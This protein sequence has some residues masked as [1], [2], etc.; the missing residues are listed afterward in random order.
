MSTYIFSR[1]RSMSARK[2]ERDLYIQYKQYEHDSYVMIY[3]DVKFNDK[4]K[5]KR[6]GLKWNLKQKT[7]QWCRKIELLNITEEDNGDV[8]FKKNVK[9]LLKFDES[10]IDDIGKLQEKI[11]DINYTMDKK[12]DKCSDKD[13]A[14]KIKEKYHEKLDNIYGTLKKSN[15]AQELY[16]F[17]VHHVECK[18]EKTEWNKEKNIEKYG[19]VDDYI[20]EIFLKYQEKYN[21]RRQEI[22]NSL[23]SIS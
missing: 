9:S 4:E 3:Y 13:E 23:N 15:S 11:S 1:E 14:E 8:A 2:F 18:G 5:A 10:E 6:N 20:I 21:A 17:P 16:L 7:W 19:C 22:S 12:L